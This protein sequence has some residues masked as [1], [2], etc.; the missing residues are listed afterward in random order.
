VLVLG[1]GSGVS[2][3]ALFLALQVAAK[4]IVTS[5]SDEK[6][7]R[8]RALGA[9]AGVNYTAGDWAEEVRSLTDGKGVDLVVDSVGSTWP[10]SIRCLRRGG[11]LVVFG[12]TGGAES[13]LSARDVY[14]GQVSI[15]G[16]TMGSPREFAGLLD[17]IERGT[18]TPAIDSV[19]PLGEAATAHERMDAGSH[20][21]KL[22]L[23][24]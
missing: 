12:A 14:S 22:V 11:R 7:E 2:T 19:R 1:I 3:F 5:S 24:I 9:V 16:T 8:A 20:F 6:L 18:W 21:G 17:A 13:T 15:L 23:E 4:V 10:D